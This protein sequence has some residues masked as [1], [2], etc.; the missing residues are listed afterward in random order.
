[1]LYTEI[2]LTE[3]IQRTVKSNQ[4]ISVKKRFTLRQRRNGCDQFLI[5]T[6]IPG[7][8]KAIRSNIH[9]IF[10]CQIIS[11]IIRINSRQPR[12]P[13]FPYRK[14]TDTYVRNRPCKC[15]WQKLLMNSRRI[16]KNNVLHICCF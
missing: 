14:D 11:R 1:M 4:L 12:F 6:Y 16:K 3:S 7:N 2:F 5:R 15:Q 9:R 8:E 13:F 10:Y